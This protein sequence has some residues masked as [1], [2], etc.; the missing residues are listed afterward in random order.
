[1]RNDT[2]GETPHSST[3]TS[4]KHLDLLQAESLSRLNFQDGK[5]I[6]IQYPS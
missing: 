3:L 4:N 6:P 5:T 1:M 2:K